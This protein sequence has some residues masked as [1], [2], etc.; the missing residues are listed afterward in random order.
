V[1][2]R[3]SEQLG[4]SPRLVPALEV[5]IDPRFESPPHRASAGPP[6]DASSIALA[7]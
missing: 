7:R 3:V 6:A 4:R 5:G 2:E 1:S